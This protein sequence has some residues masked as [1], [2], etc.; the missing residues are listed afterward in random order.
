[1]LRKPLSAV[2][3]NALKTVV[4]VMLSAFGTFWIGE[5][6]GAAWPG[7]DFSLIGLV[8]GFGVVAW[9]SVRLIA[10]QRLPARGGV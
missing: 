3:E 5:G 6:F 2:P 7:E 10:Q 1:M 4:G 8:V 9:L